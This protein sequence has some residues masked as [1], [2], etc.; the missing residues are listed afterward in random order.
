MVFQIL[1][2]QMLD[3]GPSNQ[4]LWKN[5]CLFSKK[6]SSQCIDRPAR[7]ATLFGTAAVSISRRRKAGTKIPKQNF[8]ESRRK[9]V[10]SKGSTT[11]VSGRP[12]A[13]FSKKKKPGRVPAQKQRN[14]GQAVKENRPN[15]KGHN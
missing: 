9:T 5:F 10:V 13:V 2:K 14:L 4:A 7:L 3:H 12:A 15:A 6:M 11:S 1:K 8:S